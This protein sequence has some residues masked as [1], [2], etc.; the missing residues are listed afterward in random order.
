MKNRRFIK[1]PIDSD[2]A[3]YTCNKPDY[4]GL[5]KAEKRSL[6]LPLVEVIRDFYKDPENRRKFEE[7]KVEYLRQD[8]KIAA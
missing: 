2:I 7:W 8:E 3:V 6:L 5:T 1:Q 4:M